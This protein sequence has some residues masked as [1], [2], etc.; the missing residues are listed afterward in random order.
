MKSLERLLTVDT[1]VVHPAH[2]PVVEDP[3]AHITQD[4]THRN[5][6]ETQIYYALVES[7]GKA[8]TAMEIVKL[9]YKVSFLFGFKFCQ[10]TNS[11]LSALMAH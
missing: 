3:V 4:I 1:D 10:R 5:A 9:V 7:P 11:L 6:R 2:G 8:L